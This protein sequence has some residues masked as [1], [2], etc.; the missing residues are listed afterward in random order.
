[1]LSGYISRNFRATPQQVQRTVS[2]LVVPYLIVEPLYQVIHRHYSGTPDPYRFLSPQ[3]VA[4]FLAALLVW[5]VSTP[6]W[7]NLRHPILVAVI[8]S[9]LVPLTE[10]PNVFAVPKM[11]GLLPFYVVGMHMTM[12]R[13]E[14]L[15]ATR[16]R[17]ASIAFLLAVAVASALYSDHW[18]LAWTKW[19]HRYDEDPLFA[20]PPEGIAL[21]GVVLL[22]GMLMCFAVLSLV[23][24][25]K[26]WT[27]ALGGR[28]LYCYLLHG[29]I[30]LFLAM[31]TSA[32]HDLRNL[33]PVGV[34]IAIAGALVAAILLMT[35]PIE[36]I[37]RFVFEP[38][39]D[40]AFS[41][42]PVLPK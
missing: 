35:R 10:V 12:E 28:T 14:R 17:I 29:F 38:K 8:I 26:S 27:S 16:V 11:F 42:T 23:P 22:V 9:L 13:F 2:T 21:R 32:F 4:W 24:W 40:W 5:R 36:R 34:V 37:F 41:P 6:I 31:E 25:A 30:V 19:R 18:V 15:A 33:G 39:L 7:R 1:M 3:W 20:G